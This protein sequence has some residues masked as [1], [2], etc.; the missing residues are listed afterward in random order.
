MMRFFRLILLVVL[1]A[2]VCLPGPAAAQPDP[3]TVNVSEIDYEAWESAANRA[4][5]LVDAGRASTAFFNNLRAEL[6]RWRAVFLNAQSAA[7]ASRISTIEAQIAALGPPPAD[8]AA[9]PEAIAERRAD[10]NARLAEAQVPRVNATE[11]YNRANALIAEI[12]AILV[13][14]QTQALLELSPTPLNPV[15]WGTTL[16]AFGDLTGSIL[17]ET[18]ANLTDSGKLAEARA[19]LGAVLVSLVAGV[20]LLLFGRR[21]VVRAGDWIA[22][23]KPRAG[24]LAL[25]FVV[26][27]GQLA[28]P[29]LGIVLILW[30]ISL[31]G[32]ASEALMVLLEATVE[33]AVVSFFGL[34]LAGRLFSH[35]A[36]RP[37][38]LA[39]DPAYRASG[40]RIVAWIA[41]G[42][43]ITGVAEAVAGLDVVPP[44][45]RGVL[46]LPIYLI[47]SIGYWRLAAFLLARRTASDDSDVRS[48]ALGVAALVARGLQAVAIAGPLLAAVGYLNAA[49][50]LIIPS[51][52]TLSVLGL[53]AAL[54]V[55]IRDLFALIFRTTYEASADALTPVLINFSLIFVTV[56]VLA[57]IWGVRPERIADAIARFNEGF[58]LGDTRITPMTFLAVLLVFVGGFLVTRLLQS[59]LRTSVLP[60]TKLDT[61]ARNAVVSGVGYVGIALAALIAITAGGIDLTALGFVLGALSVGIGFGLQNVVSNFVSGIILLIE[62]PIS[63]GDWIEVNGNMGIVKDISVRSTRIETFDKTDVIVPNADFISGTVTNWT[64]GNTIG[65]AVLTVGV[66]YGTDTRRVQEILLEIARSH[67]V[68]ATFPE[69]GV[70]FLGFGADSLDFRIRAILRDVN[71]LISVQTEM[72]HQI[73]ERFAAEGIEIPFAQR[74]I[75]LRNPETLRSLSDAPQPKESETATTQPDANEAGA[76]KA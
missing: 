20:L 13:D 47:L 12:D 41:I 44:P 25:D 18:Y 39:T 30:A 55:V 9:E 70:D 64:R 61:G 69:P 74:D 38:F 2:A 59:G 33:L 1:T 48:S 71:Q 16:T 49:E 26:S 72:N 36:D 22:S 37:A 73:A 11:A 24:R 10:L 15:N 65:R 35:R 76:Q 60:R 5:S 56:P 14:R 32:M 45:A 42:V 53:L 40:R 75:W 17:S 58:L 51:A 27:L 28:L 67:P 4:E 68:V 6:V 7:N 54:Q 31:S 62:R 63:E 66:A 19:A 34:W 46:L 43:G 3:A 8:G 21:L 52:L 50:E 23:R 29:L 57:L